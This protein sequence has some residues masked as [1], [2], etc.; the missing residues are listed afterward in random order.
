MYDGRYSESGCLRTGPQR[1][2]RR[3]H[4]TTI[5]FDDDAGDDELEFFHVE[6]A[7]HDV[8][9]AEG[10]ACESRLTA[11]MTR[12]APRLAMNGGRCELKSRL[13]SA[14]AIVVDRRTPFDVVRD[15]LEERSLS[16]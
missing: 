14:A 16:L 3:Q 9:D 12:C 1:T 13:R 15:R 5:A 11:A 7:N 6:L 10:A 4:C 2:G 8:I